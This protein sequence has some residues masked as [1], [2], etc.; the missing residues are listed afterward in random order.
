MV[1]VRIQYNKISDSVGLVGRFHFYDGSILLYFLKIVIDRIAENKGR[2]ASDRPL[3][4]LMSAQMHAGIPMA[5][6]RVGTELKVLFEPEHVL[7]ILKSISKAAHLKDRTN[8]LRFHGER[9][10]ECLSDLAK[11]FNPG[12]RSQMNNPEEM[13]GLSL[14][15]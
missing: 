8:A 1:S 7:I 4:N 2:T 3:M 10:P 12:D 15:F 14:A 6:A 9:M 13:I 11:S 5:N